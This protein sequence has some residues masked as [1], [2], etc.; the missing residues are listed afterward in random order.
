[1][2]NISKRMFKHHVPY[3]ILGLDTH[4]FELGPTTITKVKEV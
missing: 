1:M 4:F 3:I 2:C